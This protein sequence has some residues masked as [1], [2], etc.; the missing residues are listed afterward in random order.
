MGKLKATVIIVIAASGTAPDTL[1]DAATRIAIWTCM[2][3]TAI[4]IRWLQRIE[5]HL[6]MTHDRRTLPPYTL[7]GLFSCKSWQL[8]V[9]SLLLGFHSLPRT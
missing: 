6:S 2:P 8:H 9:S 4:H 5:R 7:K 3:K 1:S